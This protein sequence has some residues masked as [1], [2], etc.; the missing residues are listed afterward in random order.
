MAD[1]RAV[2]LAVA[3]DIAEGRSV[4][5]DSAL[6]TA[7]GEREQTLIRQLR[8]VAGLAEVHRGPARLTSETAAADLTQTF[9]NVEEPPPA[10]VR[11]WAHL[12]LR[13]RLGAGAFGMVYRAWDARLDREVALKL[14]NAGPATRVAVSRAI[15]EG[16][17]LAKLRHPNVVTIYGAEVH[18]GQVGIWMEYVRGRSL[19]EL[20]AKQGPFGAHE[21]ALIGVDLCRALAAAHAAGVIHRDVKASNVLREQG[22]RILLTDFGAGLELREADIAA[23]AVSGTPLYMAPELF[24]GGSASPRSDLYSLGVLLFRLVTGSYPVTGE[25]WHELKDKHGRREREL[26]RDLRPELPAAFTQA[27][28]RAIAED[29]DERYPTAGRM[30]QALAGALGVEAKPIAVATKRA[31]SLRWVLAAGAIVVLAGALA[32]WNVLWNDGARPEAAPYRIEA[33]IYR[34]PNGSTERQRIDN[35]ARL[36]FGDA[37]EL[38]LRVSAPVHVYVINKDATG[39][40]FALFPMPGYVPQNPLAAGTHRLPGVQAGLR[41]AWSPNEGGGREQMLVLATPERLVEFEAEMSKLARPG[42]AAIAIP[43]ASATI[44]RGLSGIVTLPE[45]ATGSGSADALFRMAEHFAGAAETVEG[46]WLRQIELE[47]PP[48]S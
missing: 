30:E 46:V 34:T 13:E 38:E 16:R 2:A 3:D 27:V 33:A 26:L 9:M 12:E 45:A 21:A 29:P 22:G 10:S 40:S 24:H 32:A 18:G 39:R 43:E 41:R 42:D 31:G 20:L 23:R 37:I 25:T 44:L 15:E 48:S 36:E 35:G 6:R 11:V 7:D 1:D 17:L 14:L 4:D 28:E 19:E 5:W 47:G 8:L